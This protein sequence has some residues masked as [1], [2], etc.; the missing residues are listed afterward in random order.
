MPKKSESQK[1]VV[2]SDRIKKALVKS[3]AEGM[4]NLTLLKDHGLD[5][6]GDKIKRVK[7]LAEM[8]IDK[9]IAK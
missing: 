2:T 7:A 8:L 6:K 4:V 9:K 3:D 1:G 5:S